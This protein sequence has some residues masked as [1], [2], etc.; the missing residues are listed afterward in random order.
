VRLPKSEA[1]KIKKEAREKRIS[2]SKLVLNIIREYAQK[3]N[4]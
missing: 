4:Q 1:E 2:V 3:D